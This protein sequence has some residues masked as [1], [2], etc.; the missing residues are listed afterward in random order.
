MTDPQAL[1]PLKVSQKARDAAADLVAEQF[2]LATVPV[3]IRAGEDDAHPAVEA[4]AR[5]EHELQSPANIK[6]VNPEA[7]ASAVS[8]LRAWGDSGRLL[9]EIENWAGFGENVSLVL[10][11]LA[12]TATKLAEVEQD[13]DHWLGECQRNL[14]AGQ[15]AAYKLEGLKPILS[16]AA[17]ALQEM[18]AGDGVWARAIA[19]HI[20]D[21]EECDRLLAAGKRARSAINAIKGPPDAD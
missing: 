18:V 10:K 1:P 2:G 7:L 3:Q 20:N 8:E 14:R 12:S 6:S 21:P 13:R 17:E 4:F 15:D 9:D 16:Q 19:E 11:A 5:F